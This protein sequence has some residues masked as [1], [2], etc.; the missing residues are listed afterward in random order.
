MGSQVP[1]SSLILLSAYRNQ[2]IYQSSQ[3]LHHH[4]YSLISH[5]ARQLIM[6][7]LLK[8]VQSRR[9]QFYNWN[10]HHKGAFISDPI[11]LNSFT[12]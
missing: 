7:V 3:G 10:D 4:G 5:S 6:L 2:S 8:V 11:E 1:F 12:Y 9:A